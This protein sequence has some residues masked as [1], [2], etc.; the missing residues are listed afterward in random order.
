MTHKMGLTK[1]EFEWFKQNCSVCSLPDCG[2]T[3]YN[4]HGASHKVEDVRTGNEP[5]NMGFEYPH[6]MHT[7]KETK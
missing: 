2:D 4:I 7:E 6:R 1:C 3:V 5:T